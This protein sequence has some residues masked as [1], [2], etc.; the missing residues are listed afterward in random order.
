MHM[1]AHNKHI[2]TISVN[3]MGFVAVTKNTQNP[4]AY[5]ANN[6]LTVYVL[7]VTCMFLSILCHLYLKMQDS[8]L[9]WNTVVWQEEEETVGRK[10]WWCL[11][12]CM[13]EYLSIRMC[14]HFMCVHLHMNVYVRVCVHDVY[15]YLCVCVWIC[16]HLC[17]FVLLW[18]CN[19]CVCLCMCVYI[20]VLTQGNTLTY[21]QLSSM[22]HILFWNI[23]SQ[24]LNLNSTSWID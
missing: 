6:I 17:I 11:C 20:C 5:S 13:Y 1:E 24:L 16:A 7:S 2:P 14:M 8:S 15:E 10:P 19:M 18:R 12:V 22:P 21:M 3:R 4:L 9:S 23:V